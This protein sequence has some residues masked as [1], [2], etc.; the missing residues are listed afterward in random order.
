[1]GKPGPKP[2]D[3]TFEEE[4]WDNYNPYYKSKEPTH[5]ELQK[6]LDDKTLDRMHK[7]LTQI[8]EMAGYE[9]SKGIITIISKKVLS[10]VY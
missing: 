3:K 1:M 9:T 10:T 8:A 2:K 6:R 4:V 5:K 7:N